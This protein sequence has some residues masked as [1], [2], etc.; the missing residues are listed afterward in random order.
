MQGAHPAVIHRD[1]KSS[2]ILIDASGQGRICD[3]GLARHK[4]LLYNSHS[5]PAPNPEGI[6]MGTYGYMAPEYAASGLYALLFCAA[7]A[8]GLQFCVQYCVQ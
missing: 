4:M 8:L 2:N 7:R 6:M 3:F 1:L 5:P